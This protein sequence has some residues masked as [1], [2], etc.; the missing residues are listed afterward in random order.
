MNIKKYIQTACIA[1]MAVAASPIVN[2]MTDEEKEYIKLYGMVVAEQS[3]LKQLNLSQDEFE[4]FLAGLKEAFGGAQL[5]ENVMDLAPKMGEYL[6]ARAEETVRKEVEKTMAASEAFWQKLND[7]PK[8]QKSPSGLAYVIEQ[9]GTAPLAGPESE[10][11]IRYKGTLID[12]TVFDSSEKAPDGVA[13]FG[14]SQVIPGFAEGLQKL[15]KGGKAR[16]YIPAS[17]GYGD[18]P[19]RS[20]P[21]GSTLIFDIEVIDV[22]NA[23]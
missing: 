8:V 9:V 13:T 5:P 2:A 12:G 4:V 11:V 19:N 14:V 1:A 22:R 18:Q 23:E 7:N 20:I 10:V 17:L 21:A 6:S 3:G 16:L 15:G